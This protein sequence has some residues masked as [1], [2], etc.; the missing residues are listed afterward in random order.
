MRKIWILILAAMAVA[1]SGRLEQ[2]DRTFQAK[3]SVNAYFKY[4]RVVEGKLLPHPVIAA[5]CSDEELKIML[6]LVGEYAGSVYDLA[7]A[8]YSQDAMDYERYQE[9]FG[10][11]N[12]NA[13]LYRYYTKKGGGEWMLES[14]NCKYYAYCEHIVSIEITS[15]KYWAD[16]YAAGTNLAPLFTVE[17]TS[18]ADYVASGF[19]TAPVKVYREVVSELNR[20]HTKLMMETDYNIYGGTD[21]AFFTSTVPEN[22]PMHKVTITFNL[23]TGESISYS[24][25]LTNLY[26]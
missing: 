22:L 3:S 12:P 17:Y 13:S 14:G 11:F 23:D 20:E 5:D 21:M 6:S 16:G 4:I 9:K 1:C 8:P 15:D 7:N 25:K 19:T 10:D 24:I 2:T 26:M 18:L